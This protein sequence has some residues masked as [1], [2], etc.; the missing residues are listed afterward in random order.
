[1]HY[2]I[3]RKSQDTH[4]QYKGFFTMC[5][6]FRTATYISVSKSVN[7][8]SPPEARTFV[9]EICCAR[10]V[11]APSPSTL[12]YACTYFRRQKGGEVCFRLCM[13]FTLGCWNIVIPTYLSTIF[14][15]FWSCQGTGCPNLELSDTILPCNA[16]LQV[17]FKQYY[18]ISA[19]KHPIVVL[20]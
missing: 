13:S 2:A 12:F 14:L 3:G 8:L 1:M 11:Q 19:L 20:E 5:P 7:N 16:F 9:I 15:A 17:F 10:W 4:T 6:M 18:S